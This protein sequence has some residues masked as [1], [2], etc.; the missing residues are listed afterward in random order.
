MLK[1]SKKWSYAVK[2][3]IYIANSN[4]ELVHI[5]DISKD[6]EIS[7]SLLRR[8]VSNLEK[9]GIL[10]TVKWRYGGIK[11]WKTPNRI[12][13]YDILDS[14]GEELWITDCTRGDACDKTEYCST[15][16]LFWSLQT[17]FNSLLKMY[18]L[19]KIIKNS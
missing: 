10:I 1:L 16:S 14:I 3:M 7:E 19:D 12:S 6:E 11:L 8:I 13:T 17:G 9:S 4:K 18:T 5:S 2:A 15:T